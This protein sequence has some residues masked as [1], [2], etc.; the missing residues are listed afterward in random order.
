MKTAVITGGAGGL[1]RA[2]ARGLQAQG[3]H[4]VL[5]DIDV[6]GLETTHIH[7][8][9]QE[10][11]LSQ[12]LPEK[13]FSLDDRVDRRRL[14]RLG[15]ELSHAAQPQQL[16]GQGELVKRCAEHF[17]RHMLVQSVIPVK[18]IYLTLGRYS[19]VSLYLALLQR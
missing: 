10:L 18:N 12:A 8:P 5:F 3:W 19:L 14:Q 6:T 7:V 13:D 16:D 11:E 1:G 15:E 4:T 2:M 9:Q 17:R